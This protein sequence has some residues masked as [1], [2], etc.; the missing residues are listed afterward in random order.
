MFRARWA[1]LAT[2]IWACLSP[3]AAWSQEFFEAL[4]AAYQT[5]PTLLAQR[6]NLRAVNEGVPQELSNYRPFV[7]IESFAGAQHVD[8]NGSDGSE[9][10]TPYQASVGL[11]QP[12]YRGGRTVAGVARAESEVA[13]QRAVLRSV[14]QDVL[15]GA[16]TAYMDVWRDQAVLQLTINNEQ[17]LARQLEATQDRFDVGELTRTDVAQSEARLARAT[18]Q[19]IEAEGNLTAS[20]AVF[21]E[22]VGFLPGTLEAPPALEGLPASEQDVVGAARDDNPAVLSARF[23]EQA[24][25]HQ[26]RVTT[27]E[28]LPEVFL[29]AELLHS[30]NEFSDDSEI[31]QA[32]VLAVVSI[33]LYQQ[34]F[35]SSRVRQAK[36]DASRRRVEIVEARRRVEQDAIDAWEALVTARAQIRSFQSEVRSSEIALEG[37]R[38]ENSVGQRTILDVLDAEQELLDAQVRLVRARRDEVVAAY[39]IQQVQGRLTAAELGLP[40]D[41]YDAE[42]DYLAVRDRWFG[43][44]IPEE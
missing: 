41:V 42:A 10:T 14:E 8:R 11:A 1:L 15:L 3:S 6:A 36:Q 23:A 38:E 40:V 4:V 9:S 12:L 44:D 37:V 29:T 31:S 5:N 13:A 30:E 19:R 32:R 17:V 21:Q 16:V 18:A 2:T 27:G 34:G 39:R 20:R 24:A 28:L 33:P 7:S 43:L 26:V 25:R 35:V 22:V